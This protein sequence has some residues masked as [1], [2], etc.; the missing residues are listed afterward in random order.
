M[1]VYL[2]IPQRL[3]NAHPTAAVSPASARHEVLALRS[4]GSL[5]D[6]NCTMLWCDAL[7]HRDRDADFS[8]FAMLHDDILPQAYW[9]DRMIDL[10]E[11][12]QADFLSAV[13]PLKDDS[14]ATSTAI[15][16]PG[17]WWTNYCRLTQAQVRHADFADVFD[18]HAA[19]DAVQ[20]LPAEM[21]VAEV[22]REFLLANTGCMVCRLDRPW[23]EHV[24]FESET[25]LGKIQS[26]RV[27]LHRSEDW[28]FSA[29][30]AARGGKVMATR[31]IQLLH[32]DQAT[33]RQ[34]N[35]HA[36]WGNPRDLGYLELPGWTGTKSSGIS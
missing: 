8:Y 26:T 30:I 15:S 11:E 14:G 27:V 6:R 3:D 10:L 35:S 33:G 20:R 25:R 17:K 13:V 34:F 16:A 9:L 4:S 23:A 19:A 21:Q 5:I 18:V 12:H 32:I 36:I 24:W 31:L 1:K 2:G 22:P 29:M 28:R 7:I